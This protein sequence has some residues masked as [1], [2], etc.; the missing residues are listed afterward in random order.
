M[1]T[2]LDCKI[3]EEVID[4]TPDWRPIICVAIK[5]I[6]DAS[7]YE[8]QYSKDCTDYDGAMETWTDIIL[9]CAS[10]LDRVNRN[11]KSGSFPIDSEEAK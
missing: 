10:K 11:I 8:K 3:P 6:K 4:I 1:T 9:D 7:K 2:D 5:W